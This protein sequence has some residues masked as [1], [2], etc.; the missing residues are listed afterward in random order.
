[1]RVIKEGNKKKSI[2]IRA[3]L[4]TSGFSSGRKKGI[5]NRGIPE[6]YYRN[7]AG[8]TTYVYA[9]RDRYKLVSKTDRKEAR[10]FLLKIGK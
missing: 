4:N 7:E 9:E 5:Q 2:R 1:M 6:R 3:I 10:N 8:Y